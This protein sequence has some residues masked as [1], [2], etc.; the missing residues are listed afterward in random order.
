MFGNIISHQ[1]GLSFLRVLVAYDLY[2]VEK[3][4]SISGRFS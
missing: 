3:P 2:G 1:N 4:F